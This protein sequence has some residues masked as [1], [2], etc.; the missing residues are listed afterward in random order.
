[1][2]NTKR[3]AAKGESGGRVVQAG[4]GWGVNAGGGNRLCGMRRPGDQEVANHATRR[5]DRGAVSPELVTV[6]KLTSQKNKKKSWRQRR[7]C[8]V[9]PARSVM[10]PGSASFKLCAWAASSSLPQSTIYF[11]D[12]DTRG[13]MDTWGGGVH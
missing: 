6:V 11:P 2:W 5:V 12:V 8:Q 4:V 7:R 3:A 13:D 9:S 1:M 10:T